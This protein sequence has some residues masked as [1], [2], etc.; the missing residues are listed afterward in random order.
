MDRKDYMRNYMRNKRAGKKT[1]QDNGQ[2]HFIEELEWRPIPEFDGYAVSKCGHVLSIARKTVRSN[3]RPHSIPAKVLKSWS[4]TNGYLQV[5][6]RV[7]GRRLYRSCHRLVYTAWI[8]EIPKDKVVDHIDA[9]K[10]NNNA[11][12]LQLLTCSQ[13]VLKGWE[14][15]KKDAYDAGYAEGAKQC[16]QPSAKTPL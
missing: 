13:N 7:D 2:E 9:D 8:G 4:D 5:S 10:L 1:M 3:G 12:N 14:D 11:D 15:A 16:H 6:F